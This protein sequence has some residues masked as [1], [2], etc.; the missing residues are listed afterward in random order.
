MGNWDFFGDT[1]LWSILNID[2]NV[3]TE[4]YIR[5]SRTFFDSPMVSYDI[6]MT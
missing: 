4:A 3:D 5:V 1:E 6:N 2:D